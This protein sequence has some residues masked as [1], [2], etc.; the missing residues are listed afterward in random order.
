MPF[1]EKVGEMKCKVCEATLIHPDG[2]KSG[3]PQARCDLNS[4]CQDTN[5]SE[6]LQVCCCWLKCS[7][8]KVSEKEE[9]QKPVYED[10]IVI[11]I[12]I[13]PHLLYFL[14]LVS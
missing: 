14:C 5:C 12:F 11:L 7:A 1:D 9:F 6:F 2:S 13:G 10:L 3:S 4:I 8:W